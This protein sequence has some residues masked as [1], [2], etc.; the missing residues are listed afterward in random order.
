[1]ASEDRRRPHAELV[2]DIRIRGIVRSCPA[3]TVK[4]LGPADELEQPLPCFGCRGAHER[5]LNARRD[6][7]GPKA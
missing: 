6:R 5:H 4:A 3:S 2:H 7:T 1:M